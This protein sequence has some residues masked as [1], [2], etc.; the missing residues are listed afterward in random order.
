M[1][2]RH[3][4][5]LTKAAEGWL[6]V[7]SQLRG[8]EKGSPMPT[9]PSMNEDRKRAQ[10]MATQD[11][12]NLVRQVVTDPGQI[13]PTIMKPTGLMMT[14]LALSFRSPWACAAS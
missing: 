8:R 14:A 12:K 3:R 13:M 2:E 6:F 1:T 4:R 9:K 11:L 10:E 5:C 7:A